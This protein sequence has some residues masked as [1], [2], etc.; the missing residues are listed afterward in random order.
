MRVEEKKWDDGYC[1]FCDRLYDVIGGRHIPIE[2]DCRIFGISR[3]ARSG[4]YASICETCVNK[5]AAEVGV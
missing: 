2:P 5:L 3:D 4:L 1:N